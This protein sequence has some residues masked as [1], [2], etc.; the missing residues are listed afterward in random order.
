MPEFKENADRLE[1]NGLYCLCFDVILGFF[2]A[3]SFDTMIV[4]V[5]KS[6]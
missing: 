1:S 4:V 2:F 5:V 6:S 3:M